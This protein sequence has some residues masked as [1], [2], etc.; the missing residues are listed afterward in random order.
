[1]K[2]GAAYRSHRVCAGEGIDPDALGEGVIGPDA[3]DDDDA[4]L[5]AVE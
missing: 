4:A 2:G 3:F 1:M 5:Q